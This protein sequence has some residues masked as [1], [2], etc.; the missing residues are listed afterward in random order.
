MPRFRRIEETE[1]SSEI[2]TPSMQEI[3]AKLQSN[4]PAL[5]SDRDIIKI[6]DYHGATVESLVER[7]VSLM[8]GTDDEK[9]QRDLILEFLNMHGVRNPQDNTSSVINLVIKDGNVEVQNILMPKR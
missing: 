7:A 6:L 1:G 8:H 4:I 5:R 3:G 9:I 2:R